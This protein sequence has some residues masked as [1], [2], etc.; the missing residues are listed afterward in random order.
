MA[1]GKAFGHLVRPVSFLKQSKACSLTERSTRFRAPYCRVASWESQ[2]HTAER[3]AE[4][5]QQRKGGGDLKAEI[6][7]ENSRLQA[8]MT[9]LRKKKDDLRMEREFVVCN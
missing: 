1:L 2:A 6:E 5:T 3:P 4:I 8:E 9:L 7:A